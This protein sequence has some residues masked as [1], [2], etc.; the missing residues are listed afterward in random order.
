MTRTKSFLRQAGIAAAAAAL[1]AGMALAAAAHPG[2]GR[3]R[4]GRFGDSDPGGRW[5]AAAE[6]LDLTDA[7]RDRLREVRRSAPG[8]LMPKRQ[9]LTEARMDLQDLM[10]RDD[11]DPGELRRAH[12]RLVDARAALA[13]ATF[14]LRL[15]AREVLTSEQL[16]KL[17]ELRPRDGRGE[18]REGRGLR[19][20][21]RGRGGRWF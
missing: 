6:R 8:I 9:A 15:Q 18:R 17:Q 21:D 1:L 13:S 4:G 7:Q 5:L 11:A 16:Q 12:E 14:D 3:H 19:R 10:R 2:G 20:G